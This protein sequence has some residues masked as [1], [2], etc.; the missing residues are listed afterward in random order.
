MSLTHVYS[1]PTLCA[2]DPAR[3]DKKFNGMSEPLEAIATHVVNPVWSS[4]DGANAFPRVE[5]FVQ[6]VNT[7]YA[8][9]SPVPK[10][11]AGIYSRG[12]GPAFQSFFQ[13]DDDRA[14]SVVRA[15]KS[16]LSMRLPVD[17]HTHTRQYEFDRHASDFVESLPPLYDT[18]DNKAQFRYFIEKY[19]TSFA[20][21]ATLGGMVEQYS[22]WKT[23][24]TDARL[25]DFTREKL[26]R[27]AGIDFARATGL[28]GPAVA[29]DS[30]YD[31]DHVVVHSL[32]CLGG[33]PS[34]GCDADFA[35]WAKTVAGAPVLLEYELS[36]ISDLVTDPA[37]KKALDQAVQEY[38][39]EK[40]AEWAA[41]DKCPTNCGAAGAGSCVAGRD[42]SCQCAYAGI[43]GR[44]CTG[45]APM[46]AKG[47]FTDAFG[48]VQTG[49][50]TVPCDGTPRAFWSGASL[51]QN[52]GRLHHRCSA[53]AVASCARGSNGNLQA[54]L[55]Q[56]AC[57]APC[58]S[59]PP[60][61]QEEEEE[62]E[63]V[64]RRLLTQRKLPVPI[65]SP[66]QSIPC[67]PFDAQSSASDANPVTDQ[68][69]TVSLAG[70]DVPVKKSKDKYM[71]CRTSW[72]K[73]QKAYPFCE[74]G[75]TCEFAG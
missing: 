17:P 38:V 60:G 23:W 32:A 24:L 67:G 59:S 6:H 57:D 16:L 18:E 64:A 53:T 30:G 40:Q 63:E 1:Q 21:S 74:L 43:V 35:G 75:V 36:P 66:R 26:V 49:T 28:P 41:V 20:T 70:K 62:E 29:H 48:H 12:F 54:V 10:G 3:A 37:V 27:N 71:Y 11:T 39:R 50:A 61:L 19:G 22:S 52:G 4:T 13:M 65:C 58:S 25:G 2:D 56:P 68:A 15:S 51:C 7:Q 73:K 34:V 31:A 8:G 45:C 5:D 69:A 55:A 9:A 47:T 33:N 14:L 44:M 42:S 46:T 72:D